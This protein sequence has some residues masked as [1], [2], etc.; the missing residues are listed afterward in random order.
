ML[1][2]SGEDINYEGAATSLDWDP[3]GDVTD[4]FVSIWAHQSGEIK[5]FRLREEQK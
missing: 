5:D 1:I 3:A 4:G 2:R